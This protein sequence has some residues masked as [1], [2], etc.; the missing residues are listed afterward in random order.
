MDSILYVYCT[1][2]KAKLSIHA[3]SRLSGTI[4]CP[5]CSHRGTVA[6]FYAEYVLSQ[7]TQVHPPKKAIIEPILNSALD[8]T[9]IVRKPQAHS[10]IAR[11]YGSKDSYELSLGLN[12]IGKAPQA[13]DGRVIRLSREDAL[14]TI[15]R[16]HCLLQIKHTPERGYIYQIMD[17][18]SMNGTML[19]GQSLDAGVY[20]TLLP[21]QTFVL[22]GACRLTLK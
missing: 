4:T 18:G 21:G 17:H 14:G 6:Q 3:H 20:Y 13:V 16:L 10:S 8:H 7:V 12:Y 2:C 9:Q 1:D 22:G 19:E 11:L 5:R 15:S